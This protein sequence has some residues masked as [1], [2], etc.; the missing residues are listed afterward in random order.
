[1]SE[2]KRNFWGGYY[3]T[4]TIGPANLLMGCEIL[5]S[6]HCG[7]FQQDGIQY[8][9]MFFLLCKDELPDTKGLFQEAFDFSAADADQIINLPFFA[10]FDITSL[11]P[12]AQAL[13]SS[14]VAEGLDQ[15]AILERRVGVMVP[16]FMGFRFDEVLQRFPETLQPITHTDEQGNEYTTNN[17]RQC[18]LE[19]PI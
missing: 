3:R 9:L 7:T 18:S 11:A 13:I 4:P 16:E 12:S 15:W 10:S 19:D 5:H 14:D 1:M 8:N 6:Y 2:L 17:I